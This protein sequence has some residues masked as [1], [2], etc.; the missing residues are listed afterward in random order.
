VH[1]AADEN[2]VPLTSK[3]Q[4]VADD[5]EPPETW[6]DVV[7]T[8]TELGNFGESP[9]GGLELGDVAL[10]LNDVPC[11]DRVRGDGVEVG[12]RSVREAERRHD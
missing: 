5:L 6:P 4:H 12:Q 3:E 2:V 9:A 10:R 8:P 7:T 11:L 1:D